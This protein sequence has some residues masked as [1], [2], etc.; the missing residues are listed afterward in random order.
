[1]KREIKKNNI[2]IIYLFDQE[3]LKGKI[4]QDNL[5]EQLASTDQF[6]HEILPMSH[7][8]VI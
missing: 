5:I 3:V 6:Q 7:K 1:M 2:L 4:L 8:I